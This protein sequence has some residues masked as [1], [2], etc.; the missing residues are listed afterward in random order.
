MLRKNTENLCKLIGE[1][2]RIYGGWKAVLCSPF[3]AL[4]CLFTV[5]SFGYWVDSGAWAQDVI[6]IIPSILGF[7]LGGYAIFMAFSDD[8]F[9]KLLVDDDEEKSFYMALNAQFVHFILVQVISIL[10]ALVGK[11]LLPLDAETELGFLCIA[12]SMFGFLVF[13]YA[14]FTALATAFSLLRFG[15]IYHK[16][17][18]QDNSNE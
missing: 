6:D 1:Y 10:V 2:W 9:L 12:F 8:N 5:I 3:L 14:L 18:A 4:S 17:K 7:S 11:Q 13:S 15:K 16:F